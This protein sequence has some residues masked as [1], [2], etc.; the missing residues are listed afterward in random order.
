MGKARAKI[1][2]ERIRMFLAERQISPGESMDS[3]GLED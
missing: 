3:R 2:E 1:L